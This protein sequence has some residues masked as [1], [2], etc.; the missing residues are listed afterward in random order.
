MDYS[1]ELLKGVKWVFF[2]LDDTLW[3][4]S[5]NSDIT[6]KDLYNN[7]SVL[8]ECYPDY[9]EYDEQYHIKNAELWDL[10]HHGKIDQ[11]Y[12]KVERFR[13][14]L[15]RKGRVGDDVDRVSAEMNEWYL[16]RLAMCGQTVDGA[17]EL[18]QRV[19]KKYLIGVLSNGFNEVQYKKLATSGLGR[20]IQRMVISDEIGV[21]KPDAR[22][23]RY[24]LDEVGA[25]AQEVLFIG[26]NPDADIRGAYEAGWRVVF[27][28]RYGKRL[29]DGVE[30]DAEI[31]SLRELLPLV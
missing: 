16:S 13:Y 31:C 18:L 28:N 12:L 10:Y 7:F 14:L 2:D 4:F 3:D 23:F 1:N 8:R 29:P 19:S 27:F 24:A 17:I 6:L 26:D 15:N 22:I 21:Q 5:A 20:Y 25:T 11:Q 9:S 30:A